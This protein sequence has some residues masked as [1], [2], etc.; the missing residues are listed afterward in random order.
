MTPNKNLSQA[1]D[2][3]PRLSAEEQAK[4]LFN[5]AYHVHMQGRLQRAIKTYQQSIEIF[6]TPEAYTF[7]GWAYSH[8]GEFDKAIAE[9]E[10]AVELDPDYGN[11]YN[12]IGA[13][14]IE[15][16]RTDE[17]EGW[18]WQAVQ[19]PRYETP[20]FPRFNLGRLYERQGKW[21]DAL[22]QY[23]LAHEIAEEIGVPY[24]IAAQTRQRL[25][26][27]LN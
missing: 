21:F 1:Q 3:S 19:A 8:L 20:F 14:L 22:D 24:T 25:Q 18:L 13:Y 7:M 15:L 27:L 26:A 12:D 23:R 9:C 11:P 4:Q 17:A 6:P 10:I 16:G 5:Q 2:S